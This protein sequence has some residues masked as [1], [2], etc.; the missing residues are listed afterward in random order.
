MPL[1]EEWKHEANNFTPWLAKADSLNTLADDLGLSELL[2]VDIDHWVGDFKLDTLC[3]DDD[4]RVIIENQLDKIN[5][6]HLG[7]LIVYALGVGAKKVIW[8]AKSFRP[9]HAAAL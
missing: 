8:A 9:K 1:R 7:R 2:L 5:H 4:D 3:T 6:T